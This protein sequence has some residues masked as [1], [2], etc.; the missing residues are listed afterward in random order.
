[1]KI[2]LCYPR[3]KKDA[4]GLSAMPIG[5]LILGT[6]L[7]KEGHNVVV[8]DASF[9]ENIHETF[10][11]IENFNPEA[12]GISL[13][14]SFYNEG[15]ELIKLCK[16]REYITILGGPH[17]TLEPESSLKENKGLD[18]VVIG[19]GEY[20]L[21]NL[22]NNLKKP[23]KVKGIAYRKNNKIVI[24]PPRER[25]KEEDLNIIID[26]DLL[27]TLPKYLESKIL[28]IV[29]YRGCP[30]NC[31]FCQPT[32]RK[33]FGNGWRIRSPENVVQELKI[34]KEKYN[35]RHFLFSDD[36]FTAN[37]KWVR[38]FVRLVYQEKLKIKFEIST[39]VN[40]NILT[41]EMLRLLKP[42]GLYKISFGVESG[43]QKILNIINKNITIDETKRAFA[44]C[45]KYDIKTNAFIML[46][47]VGETR[48]TL[49]QTEMLLDEI[50]PTTINLS[51]AT[52]QIGTDLYTI[53]EERKI[54]NFKDPRQSDYY[55]WEFKILPIKNDAITFYDVLNT[56]N[57][58]KRKRRLRFIFY[59]L[60]EE[61]KDPS[62]RRFFYLLKEFKKRKD[63]G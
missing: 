6:I 11:R 31:A 59:N 9:D 17:A 8:F 62:L 53:C 16:K 47:S 15:V 32:L 21:S 25:V 38:E 61:L 1:M 24:N 7:K 55:G 50:N 52:P 30:F 44:L 26:R 23:Q 34:L 36:T 42:I 18:F 37:H 45:K 4:R 49:R 51:M 20:T 5:V 40:E 54:L 14:T 39:R 60:K 33:L 29:V 12:V 13:L 48:G 2:A 58:I 3:T 19:E 43:S 28:N 57:R 10:K 46:G 56:K 22:I 41:E 27:E 63:K 35:P